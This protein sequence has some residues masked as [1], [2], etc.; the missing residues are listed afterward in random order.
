M[1]YRPTEMMIVDFYTKPLQ[2]K[3]FRLFR[4]L[5]LNLREEAQGMKV[6]DN[7]VYQDNQRAMK[8]EK[9]R[10]ASSGKRTRHIKI[11]C[12]FVT[13]RI[14]AKKMKVEYCPTEM[15]I[16]DFYTK[17]LQGIMFRLFRNLI[18]N[19]HKEDIQNITLSEKLT[20]METNTEDA[21][22]AI[23]IEFVQECAN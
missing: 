6:F 5:I 23:A 17:P 7:I 4:N 14:Q 9:N 13:D 2:G 15:M 3:I 18:L 1:E 21:Y 10:K 11:R 20:Q 12:F 22:H 16:S 8:L 19:L